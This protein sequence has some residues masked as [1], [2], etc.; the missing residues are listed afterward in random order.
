MYTVY[1]SYPITQWNITK[2]HGFQMTDND[3]T[4]FLNCILTIISIINLLK[5]YVSLKINR[6]KNK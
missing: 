6:Y 2:M 1:P 5:I 3:V 4:H